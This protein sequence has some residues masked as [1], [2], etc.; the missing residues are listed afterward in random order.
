MP[1]VDCGPW[2]K[3]WNDQLRG[4]GGQ[5]S[6]SHEAWRKYHCR[7]SSV[8]YLFQY[9]IFICILRYAHTSNRASD[10]YR[11]PVRTRNASFRARMCLNIL[12]FGGLIEWCSPKFMGSTPPQKK[13]LKYWGVSGNGLS[14]SKTKIH[15]N[16]K[17]LSRS[18]RNFYRRNP[19]YMCLRGWSHGCRNKSKMADGSH[20]E[21]RKCYLRP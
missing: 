10:L 11:L 3:A 18:W 7:S 21:F 12:L 20:I 6:R 1:Q 19:P 15:I 9:N 2:A 4:S 17:L 16:W 13:K 5:R 14:L 8:E